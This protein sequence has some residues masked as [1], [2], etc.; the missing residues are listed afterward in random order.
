MVYDGSLFRLREQVLY[1]L[2]SGIRRF[3]IDISE[4]SHLDSLGCGEVIRVHTSI[5]RE[6]GS[7]A[8]VNPNDRIRLLWK[9][10]RLLEVLNILDT[11]DEARDFVRGG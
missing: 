3:V 9:H 5:N 2:E 7:L 10:T 6:K 4:V 11:L 1:A 8:F